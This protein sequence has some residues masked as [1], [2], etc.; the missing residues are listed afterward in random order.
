[1]SRLFCNQISNIVFC[2]SSIIILF[3]LTRTHLFQTI[4]VSRIVI[5][6]RILKLSRTIRI[7]SIK[8]GVLR[9]RP[10]RSVDSELFSIT[11][12][13]RFL[14][15]LLLKFWFCVTIKIYSFIK[16]TLNMDILFF[17]IIVPVFIVSYIFSDIIIEDDGI[18][19][20]GDN[21]VILITVC[22]FFHIINQLF[23]L[24]DR[25]KNLSNKMKVP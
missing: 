18:V 21:A 15:V 14:I 6:T 20:I 19:R 11:F 1:M 5:N 8:T 13:F 23:V 12:I 22:L 17:V 4:H 10:A 25:C 24:R 3:F 7:R 2:C 16:I 9:S